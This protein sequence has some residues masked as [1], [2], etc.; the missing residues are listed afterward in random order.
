MPYRSTDGFTSTGN[1]TRIGG[2]ASASG[3]AKYTN[4]HPDIHTFTFDPDDSDTIYTGS[5]GGIHKSDISI[6]TPA[7]TSL[8]NNYQTYQ[9]YH[10]AIAPDAYKKYYLGGCQ[11]NG[12]VRSQNNNA[13]QSEM[14]SGDGCATGIAE[15]NGVYTEFVSVQNGRVFRRTSDLSSGYYDAEITP[16]G[17]SSSSNFVTY[18]FLD[19]DNP[20]NLYYANGPNLVRNTSATT[21]SV[22]NGWTIMTGAN[23]TISGDIS[24]FATTRG[25][26]S[27][28]TSSLF[29]GTESAKLYRLDDPENALAIATPVDITPTGMTSGVLKDISVNPRN[30]DTIMVV[31]SNYGVTSIWWTGNANNASPTWVNI[32]G[33]VTIPSVRSCEIVLTS[34]GCEYYIGTSVGLYSTSNVSGSVTWSQE[35]SSTLA[36]A[37][38]SA[39]DYRPEDNS[40]LIGT[41]G[42]GMYLAEIGNPAPHSI[43]SSIASV[44][45]YL[46]GNEKKL[47]QTSDGVIAEIENLDNFDYGLTTV[48]IDNAGSGGMNFSTNTSNSQKI[49]EKTIRITPTNTNSSGNVKITMY[50]TSTELSGW[51]TATGWFAKNMSLIKSPV[52]ISSGTVGNS[53]EASVIALD[54]TYNGDDLEITGTFSNGFS[55]LGGGK[56]GSGGPLPVEFID[57]QI[58]PTNKT[59]LI[60]WSTALEINNDRFEVNRN[61][62]GKGFEK[63]GTIK[64][65]G[66][67]LNTNEY[68]FT[69]YSISSTNYNS[70]CYQIMQ[71][72]F[73]N[74]SQSTK[75]LCHN[76]IHPKRSIVVLP[77][78]ARNFVTVNISPWN[79]KVTS[80]DIIDI[81]GNKVLESM[82]IS[83]SDNIDVSSLTDGYYFVILKQNNEIIATHKILKY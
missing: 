62:D 1:T 82:K 72:D 16:T 75:I 57:F 5:D 73:D 79:D 3:Y 44:T 59:M 42:N 41:H 60:E 39:L 66:N 20:D 74:N 35:G 32:E 56:G 10:I 31:Y 68:S 58:T 11:D 55:G 48:E 65:A 36:Y 50:F 71:I 49:T 30:D 40:L 4:H 34:T 28:S 70:V 53:V 52:S 78:P 22:T 33:N 37:L 63:I 8:N 23:A 12:T 51:K 83:E 24:S 47:F 76:K 15:K 43:E 29:I 18:F 61:V 46:D 21:A 67:S 26:Y 45:M 81:Q 27:S 6:T 13:S 14:F 64:G 54:S 69:D 2:Y 9:Y 38:V 7:W 77:N 25:P 80:V 17:A 19:P